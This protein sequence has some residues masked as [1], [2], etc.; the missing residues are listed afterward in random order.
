MAIRMDSCHDEDKLILSL[1]CCGRLT[2]E[3]RLLVV[4]VDHHPRDPSWWTALPHLTR[5]A[6]RSHLVCSF[7][8]HEALRWNS[9]IWVS[10]GRTFRTYVPAFLFQYFGTLCTIKNVICS[11]IFGKKCKIGGGRMESGIRRGMRTLGKLFDKESHKMP[12]VTQ[13][14]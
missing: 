6:Q 10:W 13:D 4:P 7:F 9:R 2:W 3:L 14:F 11:R 5:T 1:Q 12:F 8:G